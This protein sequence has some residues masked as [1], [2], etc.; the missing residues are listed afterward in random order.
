MA[1]SV[2][3]PVMGIELV[4]IKI[5]P[6]SGLMPEGGETVEKP[7]GFFRQKACGLLRA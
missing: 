4:E 2:S 6:P 5:M 1:V 3:G 7:S